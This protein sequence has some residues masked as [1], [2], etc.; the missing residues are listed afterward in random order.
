MTPTLDQWD[1]AT[2]A[3]IFALRDSLTDAGPGRLEFWETRAK[4][5]IEA[6]AAGSSTA[7]EAITACCRKLQIDTLTKD[8]SAAVV[9]GVAPIIDADYAGWAGHISRT[10][11]YIVALARVSNDEQKATRKAKREAETMKAATEEIPF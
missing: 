3:L 10:I 5:A 4:S 6:A 11:T 9:S 8:A 1:E 2:I 7:A